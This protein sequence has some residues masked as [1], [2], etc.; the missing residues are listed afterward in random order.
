M[1]QRD[2]PTSAPPWLWPVLAAGLL[3]IAALWWWAA[4]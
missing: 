1:R 4:L 3:V 2:E